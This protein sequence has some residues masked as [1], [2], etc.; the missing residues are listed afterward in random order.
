V[1]VVLLALVDGPFALR[2]PL[3]LA[4]ALVVPGFAVVGL[5][6][7]FEPTTEAVLSVVVS[8]ALGIAV[9][10]VAAWFDSYSLG[11]TLAALSVIATPCLA[12]QLESTSRGEP[13]PPLQWTR[14]YWT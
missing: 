11:V 7:L 12:L 4:Y 8:I 13:R 2:L 1:A 14:S 9:S 5:L 10:Q 3:G 6:R